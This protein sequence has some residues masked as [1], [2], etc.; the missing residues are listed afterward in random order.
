MRP[1]VTDQ[2]AWSVGLSVCLSVVVVNTNEPSMC[3]DDA[4]FLSNYC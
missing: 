2:L 4:A 1:I 3:G